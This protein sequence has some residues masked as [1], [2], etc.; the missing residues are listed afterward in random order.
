MLQTCSKQTTILAGNMQQTCGKDA[1][2]SQ[3]KCGKNAAKLQEARDK[4]AANSLLKLC[5]KIVAK[6]LQSRSYMDIPRTTSPLACTHIS[7]YSFT[8]T[9][10]G[11]FPF[12]AGS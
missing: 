11:M 3:Q 5:C 6:F 9:H 4:A 8:L 1:A 2:N 10:F 12:S 7:F